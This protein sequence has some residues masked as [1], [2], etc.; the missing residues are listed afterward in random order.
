[1]QNTTA[2]TFLRSAV[3]AT[4]FTALAGLINLRFTEK[5]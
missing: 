5:V 2:A 1:M 4:E 3:T